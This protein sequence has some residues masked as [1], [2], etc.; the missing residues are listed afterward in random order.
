MRFWKYHGLGN[1]FVLVEDH[2][3]AVRK[4]PEFA[5]RVCDRH[6]GVG[7]D[8]ILYVGAD[9][10]H[11]ATMRIINSDGSEAEMCGNGIRCVAKHLHDFGLVKKRR[12]TIRTVV[13][14]KTVECRI[15]KGAVDQ[16][17]VDMGKPTLRCEQIPMSCGGEFVSKDVEVLGTKVKGTA[18]SMGNPHF[19]TFEHFTNE[20]ME[21][22]GPAIS[23]S[24]LFPKRTNVEFAQKKGRKIQV[25]VFERGAGWTMACGTGAC[26]TAVAAV[27]NGLAKENEDV[28]IVLPGGSLWIKVNEG[29]S[30]VIM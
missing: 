4:D 9:E 16:V 7:A 17:A 12:M 5:R 22:V 20:Q 19:V 23:G 30:S 25:R 21:R 15:R 6:T 18:V 26:A 14:T 13:G 8:G 10:E 11:D 2:L 1:D 29:L 3:G 24:K 27:A 28:E